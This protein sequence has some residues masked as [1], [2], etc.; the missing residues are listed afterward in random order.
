VVYSSRETLEY[1]ALAADRKVERRKGHE[2]VEPPG[3][4][5]RTERL[6]ELNEKRSGAHDPE[7]I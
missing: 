6:H 2:I 3:P 5:D 1:A 7:G 4:G